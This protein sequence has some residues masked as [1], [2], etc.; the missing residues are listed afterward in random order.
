MSLRRI[1]AIILR[2]M[3]NFRHTY[4]RLVDAFYWP[5]VD[6]II[7]GLTFSAL[8]KQGSLSQQFVEMMLFGVILWYVIWR[9]QMEVA[10]N[11]VEEFWAENMLN[12][13]STPLKL[14]EWIIGLI[15]VGIIKLFLTILFTSLIAFIL[16]SV[17]ILTLGWWFVYF[18]ASLL[19][20]GWAFGLFIG[21]L[22]MRYGTAIQT[23]GWAGGFILMP[24]SAT[25][26]AASSLPEWVQF[27]GRFLPTM[28]VFEGMRNVLVTGTM[29]TEW[30]IKSL[31]LNCIYLLLSTI[32]FV[33]SYKAALK[34]GLNHIK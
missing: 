11:I 18:V 14:S 28:Y 32:F 7:F 16:Y 1:Y 25:Y 4:D 9:G 20:F 31:V 12:L 13:M 27:I 17:N 33:Y 19:I 26:Y 8:E 15:T 24:F 6:I 29:P 10:V 3:Y 21:G 34:K 23:L 5:A 22:F 30:I 2:H